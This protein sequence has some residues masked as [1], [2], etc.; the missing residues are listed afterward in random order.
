MIPKHRPVFKKVRFS[1]RGDTGRLEAGNHGLDS[2]SNR[3]KIGCMS[4]SSKSPKRPAHPAAESADPTTVTEHPA[5]SEY[6]ARIGRKG[7]SKGGK[8]RAKRLSPRRR[9]EIAKKAAEAR[10]KIQKDRDRQK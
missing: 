1:V 6:L 2:E 10:W 8:A 3:V 7:G 5:V 4:R 9:S